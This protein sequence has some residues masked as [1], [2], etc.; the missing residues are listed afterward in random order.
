MIT[1]DYLD[2]IIK[3]TEQVV[4]ENNEYIIKRIAKRIAATYRVDKDNLFIPA[5]INDMHKLMDAGM[6]FDEIE[7]EITKALPG[8]QNEVKKAFIKSAKEINDY[9]NDFAK[10]VVKVL[11]NNGQEIEV[12]IPDYSSEGLPTNT[13]QLHMTATE[14]R[15]L[16]QVYKSTNQTVI[17][18]C[19]TM[20]S[21]GQTAYINA[22]DN[23]FLKVQSGISPNTAIVEAILEMAKQGITTVSYDSGREDKIEVAVARAVRTGVNKANSEIVLTRAAEMGVGYVKVSAHLGARVTKREDYTNHSYWQGKVYSVDWSNPIMQKYRPTPEEEQNNIGNGFGWI[24]KIKSAISAIKTFIFGDTEKYPDFI[25]TCGYGKMLGIC[26]INCRHTFSAYVPGV[27]VED[28]T[29]IDTEENKKYYEM[30][31]KQRSMERAIRQTKRELSALK[32]SGIDTQEAKAEQRR[33][34]SLLEQQAKKYSDFCSEN[35]LSRAN[36]RLQT[37]VK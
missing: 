11:K 6:V 17:N 10:K 31:Q 5:T 18:Y 12:E 23:A 29:I 14:I 27:Q 26:G 37:G 4:A 2:E 9:N 21:A 3:A 13:A 28:E 25:E 19:K 15:K 24:N 1:P 32:A 30:T 33:L 7:R 16:E 20:P 8:I 22:C 34:R 35:N 36:W